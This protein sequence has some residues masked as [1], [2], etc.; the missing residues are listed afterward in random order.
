MISE[1][2][3]DEDFDHAHPIPPELPDVR[4]TTIA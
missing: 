3:I 2:E 4:F 1:V